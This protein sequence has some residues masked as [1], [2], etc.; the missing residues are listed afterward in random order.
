MPSEPKLEQTQALEALVLSLSEAGSAASI[1]GSM[2][3]LPAP[4]MIRRTQKLEE[5]V[6][7][8]D[9]ANQGRALPVMT[10]PSAPTILA[11]DTAT[12][13]V[14]E[15]ASNVTFLNA[16][17]AQ[18]AVLQERFDMNR[19]LVDAATAALGFEAFSLPGPIA[20]KLARDAIVAFQSGSN[21]LVVAYF[22]QIKA[23]IQCAARN[24]FQRGTERM[25]DLPDDYFDTIARD[26]TP[27]PEPVRSRATRP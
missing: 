21:E 14:D 26:G 7:E 10:I 18:A 25:L 27:T 17:R 11:T 12:R 9:A 4:P 24:G 1:A 19:R 2:P 15:L 22:D 16:C 13:I 8:V 5:W 23:Q 6:R 3:E 20:D